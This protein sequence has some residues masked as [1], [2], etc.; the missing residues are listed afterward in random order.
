MQL[1]IF[2]SLNIVV[3]VLIW[4]QSVSSKKFPIMLENYPWIFYLISV[5][6]GIFFIESSKIGIRIYDS[7]WVIRFVSI[8][9]NTIS[10]FILTNYFLGEKLDLKNG[11]CL[12]LSLTI[13]LIQIF[14]K[15]K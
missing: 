4:V 13:I 3:G 14:W 5:V 15:V 10:Y 1:I 2:F 12:I 8:S 7:V 9:I 6:I 11:I